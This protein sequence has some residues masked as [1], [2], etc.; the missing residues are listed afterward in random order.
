M[1][2]KSSSALFMILMMIGGL[3]LA[4]LLEICL[5]KYRIKICKKC[6]GRAP[7]KRYRQIS[8]DSEISYKVYECN[9]CKAVIEELCV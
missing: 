8:P 1:L 6:G 7:F 3:S 5:D 2:T 9:N 4:A